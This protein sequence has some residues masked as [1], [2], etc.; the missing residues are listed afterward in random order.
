MQND[1]A[2]FDQVIAA[3]GSLR[4]DDHSY[5][6]EQLRGN[7]LRHRDWIVASNR[8]HVLMRAWTRFFGSHDLLLC[9]AAPVPAFLRD[10]S[11]ERATRTVEVN[12]QARSVNEHLFWAGYSGV[13]YLPSTVAPIGRSPEGLPIGVQIIGPPGADLA[14]IRFAR[15]LEQAYCRFEP[16]PGFVN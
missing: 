10:H 3:A 5:Q 6:A 13:F 1:P 12:G 2:A 8:R 9:P 15:L 16:P 14:C 11:G 7:T 4:L